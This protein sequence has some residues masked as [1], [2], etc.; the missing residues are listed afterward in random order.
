MSEKGFS[1][2]YVQLQI[3]KIIFQLIAGSPNNNNPCFFDVVKRHGVNP[4]TGRGPS[5]IQRLYLVQEEIIAAAKVCGEAWHWFIFKIED[6][7]DIIPRSRCN[8]FF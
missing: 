8:K 7:W 2:Q 1:S 4:G 6:L 5:D 3:W